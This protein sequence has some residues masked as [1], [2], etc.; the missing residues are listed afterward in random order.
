MG[1]PDSGRYGWKSD[2]V[3]YELLFGHSIQ[4]SDNTTRYVTAEEFELFIEDEIVPR[5]PSGKR[6]TLG[7]LS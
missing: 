6:E 1:E 5:F 2:W 3:R 4:Q 7:N